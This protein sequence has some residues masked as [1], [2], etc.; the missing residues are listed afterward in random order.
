MASLVSSEELDCFTTALS[1]HFDTFKIKIIVHL[2]PIEKIVIVNTNSVPGYD[3][4]QN[5]TNKIFV[6][7]NQEFYA[8]VSS[9]DRQRNRNFGQL[10]IETEEGITRIKV[11][12]NARDYI[13]SRELMHIEIPKYGNIYNLDGEETP[14]NYFGLDG[15]VYYVFRLKTTK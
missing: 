5:K 12:R 14:K 8:L 13:L 6:P 15:L 1:D 3:R 2:K 10:Q 9:E 11:E 4:G 7:R